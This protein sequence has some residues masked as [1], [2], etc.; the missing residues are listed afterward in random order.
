MLL[1]IG[2]IFEHAQSVH[3]FRINICN[4]VKLLS[5]ALFA[6]QLTNVYSNDFATHVQYKFNNG[7]SNKCH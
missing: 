4:S 7:T 5:Y 6:L 1:L 3:F 2:H